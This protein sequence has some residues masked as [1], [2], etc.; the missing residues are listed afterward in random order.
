MN[1]IQKI[2][3]F[4]VKCWMEDNFEDPGINLI[5]QQQMPD[6]EKYLLDK[7]KVLEAR[8]RNMHDGIM[9]ACYQ[10][11]IL[12]KKQTLHLFRHYNYLKFCIRKHLIK[13]DNNPSKKTEDKINDFY[14]KAIEIRNLLATANFRLMTLVKNFI[15][16]TTNCDSEKQDYI[17]DAY[18]SVLRAVDNFDYRKG[19]NFNTYAAWAVQ[20]NFVKRKSSSYKTRL[21]YFQPLSKEERILSRE[22]SETFEL[23]NAFDLIEQMLSYAT[24]RQKI[25][26]RRLYALDKSDSS[27]GELLKDVGKEL[28]ISK[29]RVRQLRDDFI[30]KMQFKYAGARNEN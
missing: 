30:K 16:G 13:Y 14:T 24:D 23:E 11:P 3:D 27:K 2:R 5:I 26:I 10:E 18:S 21:K 1:D 25:I 15:A 17:S 28:G 22:S 19:F 8:N 20:N 4:T 6:Y 29:E 9:N 12:S 7:E